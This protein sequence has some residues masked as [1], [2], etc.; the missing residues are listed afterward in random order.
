MRTVLYFVWFLVPLFFFG[1]ALWS[2]LET[3]GGKQRHERPGD[4]LK[5]AFFVLVC[6]LISIGIDQW[7]LEDIATTLSFGDLLSLPLGFYQI[8]L[9]P[10]VMYAGALLVG[11]SKPI[12]ITKV[13][14]TDA[15]RQ[16]NRKK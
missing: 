8:M 7:A 16:K 12:R 3:V 5:Q 15:A 1:V 10:V 11:G 14:H 6:V 13:T 4:N 2:K 9:L